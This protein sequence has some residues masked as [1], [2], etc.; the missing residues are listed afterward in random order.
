VVDLDPVGG[1]AGR[2]D[3][4]D[5]QRGP[6]ACEDGVELEAAEERVRD[7]AEAAHVVDVLGRGGHQRVEALGLQHGGQALP[8]V[9]VHRL[10]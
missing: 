1:H 2:V 8:S 5:D 6:A 4:G 7:G 10:T 9:C 3:E